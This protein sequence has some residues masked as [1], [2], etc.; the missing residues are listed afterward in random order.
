[1]R[2]R[3]KAGRRAVR[4]HPLVCL[5]HQSQDFGQNDAVSPVKASRLAAETG[6]HASVDRVG[7]VFAAID[8]AKRKIQ[9]RPIVATV[10]DLGYQCFAYVMAPGCSGWWFGS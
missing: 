7:P 5:I 2:L 8:A 10:L 1:M 6:V 9:G 3:V 4:I